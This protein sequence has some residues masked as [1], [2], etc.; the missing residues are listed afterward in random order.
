V[1]IVNMSDGPSSPD[2]LE[3]ALMSGNSRCVVLG[4]HSGPRDAVLEG[5]RTVR[6]KKTAHK[7]CIGNIPWDK[8]SV[9]VC[10]IVQTVGEVSHR[11]DILEI[12]FN[13]ASGEAALKDGG[14]GERENIIVE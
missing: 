13:G 8:P 1:L 5:L 10:L 9:I 2:E 4:T 12:M 6:K 11:V 7:R 14:V 3:K